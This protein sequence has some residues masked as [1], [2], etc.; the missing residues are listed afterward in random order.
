MSLKQKTV[1]GIFWSSF[2]RFSV[3]GLQFVLGIIMARLLLPSDYG[4]IGMLAIFMAISQSFIDSGFSNAL[5]RKQNRTEADFSTV[6][7]FNIVVG[8]VFYFILFFAARYIAAFYNTPVLESLTKV[9][10]V[11]IFINS[12]TIVQR[13]KLTINIDFKTQSKAS[14]SAVFISGIIG[15]GMAYR[16]FGVWALAVQSIL[17][18]SI[19]M[20]ALWILSRWIPQKVFSIASFKEMFSYGSKL[21]MSGLLDTTYNNLYTI[22]IGKKF[23]KSDLGYF[24]RANSFTL[25]PS[26]NIT[27]ILQR[28]TFPILSSIQ[29]DDERL[30]ETY[31]KFLRLSAFVVFPLMMCLFAV[32]NPLIRLL[33]TDKW[34]GVVLLLQILC[35]SQMWYPIHAINLNLLQV[36][37]RSDLFLRLEIIKKAMGV[38][39]L[40]IT[41]PYG[42]VA[43]CCGTVV[44]SLIGLFINT[45]YTGKLIQVGYF[46]QMKDLLPIIGNSFSM[47]LIVWGITQLIHINALSLVIGITVGAI[48]YFFIAHITRSKELQEIISLVDKGQI[49]NKIWKLRK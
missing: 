35:L 6:F 11:N 8:L 5:I 9:V 30:R 3:Q 49:K 12:L 17:S 32:A 41:L 14:L 40:F 33:L 45:Y 43:M 23:T 38:S 44:I 19:D 16:G 39:I 26:S 42:V 13:A 37:G 34:I 31:R 24:T 29:D 47:G 25:F 36:K 15:I 46:T 7:Y 28:V 22:I 2:E 10:A 20:I 27:G 18:T 1:S 21:L 48:Y 4:I